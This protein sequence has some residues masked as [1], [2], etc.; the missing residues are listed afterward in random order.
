MHNV[1]GIEPGAGLPNDDLRSTSLGDIS[2]WVSGQGP[3]VLALHGGPAMNFD[4]LDQ[5]VEEAVGDI[6]G[7]LDEL[8]WDR[9]YLMGH[10]WGGR[11]AFHAATAIPGRLAGVLAVDPLGAVG[12]GG[13]AEFVTEL[14]ARMPDASRPRVPVGVPPR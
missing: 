6:V 5:G 11:V 7:V 10:S 3:P 1:S 12:D 8:G 9:A 13:S 14:V 2:G 4:Y